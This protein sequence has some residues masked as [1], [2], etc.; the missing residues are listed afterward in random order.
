MRTQN[1]QTEARRA[2]MKRQRI[3]AGATTWLL[4]KAATST[5]RIAQQGIRVSI[6]RMRV[7]M[8]T[9][10]RPSLATIFAFVGLERLNW[11]LANDSRQG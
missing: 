1:A 9:L 3:A 11:D 4:L 7:A 6:W 10:S 8:R 5:A 2:T